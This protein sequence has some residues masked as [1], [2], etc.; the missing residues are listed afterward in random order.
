MQEKAGIGCSKKKLKIVLRKAYVKKK[1]S[2]NYIFVIIMLRL[3]NV[4][5]INKNVIH[6]DM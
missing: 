4:A 2:T 3:N 5:L 1:L 6:D